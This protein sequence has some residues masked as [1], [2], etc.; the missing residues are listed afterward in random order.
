MNHAQC[1]R[2]VWHP[3]AL[4]PGPP[5]TAAGPFH[6]PGEW[7]CGACGEPLLTS[8]SANQAGRADGFAKGLT[9]L[10]RLHDKL[11][12]YGLPARTMASGKSRRHTGTKWPEIPCF[13]YCPRHGVCGRGQ[14]IE[15]ASAMVS[16]SD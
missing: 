15:P 14:H 7:R 6:A 4:R 1:L 13:V 16:G 10:A 8:R 5:P 2:A 9:D 11:H 3:D 12:V